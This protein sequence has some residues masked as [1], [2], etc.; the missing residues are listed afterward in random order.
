M[1]VHLIIIILSDFNKIAGGYAVYRPDGCM[2]LYL[3]EPFC[4][5]LRFF[6]IAVL[7]DKCMGKFS[8]PTQL[9]LAAC[10]VL[11]R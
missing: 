2:I 7:L 3:P 4:F 9:L 8:L 11:S 10:V 1:F 5:G 6:L